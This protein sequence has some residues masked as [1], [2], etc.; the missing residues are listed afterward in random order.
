MVGSP[1][2]STVSK[3]IF[4]LEIKNQ[5]YGP[6]KPDINESYF[7]QIDADKITIKAENYVGFVRALETVS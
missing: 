2:N 5:E 7:I 4:K 1:C 6:P 3:K